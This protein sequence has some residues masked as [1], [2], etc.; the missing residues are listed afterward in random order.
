MEPSQ[1]F[2]LTL[3]GSGHSHPVLQSDILSA[4]ALWASPA[5]HFWGQF[6]APFFWSQNTAQNGVGGIG[7]FS[8]H[9][10]CSKIKHAQ[11]VQRSQLATAGGPVSPRFPDLSLGPYKRDLTT[12]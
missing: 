7:S 1:N 5:P 9:R 4:S 2:R 12:N 10:S 6:L 11:C 8:R 3:A